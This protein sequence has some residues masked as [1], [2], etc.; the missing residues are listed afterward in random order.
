MTEF[1]SPIFPPIDQSPSANQKQPDF[2]DFPGKS[3]RQQEKGPKTLILDLDETLVHSWERPNFLETYQIYTNPEIARLFH[4]TGKSDIAYSIY[5][6]S[7]NGNSA[8][9]NINENLCIWG[10]KR[11]H[12]DEFINFCSHYFDHVLVWSAGID[13]YVQE[14]TKNIFRDSGFIS[15]RLIWSR[16][17]CSS[18]QGYFHKPISEISLSLSRQHPQTFSIDPKT[19]LILDD[20]VHTFMQNPQNGILIPPYHP[21]TDHSDRTPNL[22]DLTDRSDSALLKFMKWLNNPAVRNAEDVRFLD[23]T[24]IFE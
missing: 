9:T 12:L 17:N 7:N 18:Y 6:G 22:T 19:T 21:G 10:L 13:S 2:Y 4:P 8:Y 16:L 20:K 14:I 5:L 24:H 1:F 15:P 11:P 23:K 3:N